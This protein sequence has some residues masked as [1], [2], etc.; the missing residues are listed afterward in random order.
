M[1]CAR[2]IAKKNTL[3]AETGKNRDYRA[4]AQSFANNVLV[5]V[6]STRE[7]PRFLLSPRSQGGAV[8]KSFRE[9][10]YRDKKIVFEKDE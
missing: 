8:E 9:A 3:R 7:F 1:D 4:V 5:P 2:M 10:D 6:A